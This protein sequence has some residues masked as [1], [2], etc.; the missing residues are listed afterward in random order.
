[1]RVVPEG[2]H[3]DG[4]LAGDDQA[5]ADPDLDPVHDRP[6]R[7]VDPQQLTGVLR[8]HPHGAETGRDP[9]GHLPGRGVDAQHLLAVERGHPGGS[10]GHRDAERDPGH[11]DRQVGLAR[12]G[13]DPRDRLLLGAHHPHR[14]VAGGDAHRA[15]VDLDVRRVDRR[16]RGEGDSPAVLSSGSGAVTAGSPPQA[17]RTRS[18][19]TTAASDRD[20]GDVL[21]A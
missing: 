4:L 17:A 12:A 15:R 8:D 3:P 18:G 5:G 11:V 7:R 16:G 2:R 14:A 19:A 21:M 6:R 1:M 20:R 13:R 10:V 9:V